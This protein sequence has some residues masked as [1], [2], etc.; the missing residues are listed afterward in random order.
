MNGLTYLARMRRWRSEPH[1][2]TERTAMVKATVDGEA[3]EP[4]LTHFDRAGRARMVDVG[5][6]PET[7]RVAVAS[8]RVLMAPETRELIRQ[9]RAAKGDVLAVAQIAAVMG[10]KRTSDLIPMCHPLMLTRIEVAFDLQD[11]GVAITATVGTRGRT[12]VEMEALTAVATAALTIYD[13]LKAVD[14]GMR[15]DR[16]QLEEKRGGR[17]GEWRREHE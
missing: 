7:E 10:A 15:I 16:I 13:M 9:G 6:K 2:S 4:S 11:K 17:S 8:G 12:G 3:G 1:D 5:K 14:R